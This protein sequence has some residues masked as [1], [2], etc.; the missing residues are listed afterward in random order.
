MGRS[1][2]RFCTAENRTADPSHNKTELLQFN[3]QGLRPHLQGVSTLR[4]SHNGMCVGKSRGG[5]FL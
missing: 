2:Q 1:L 4:Q 3:G 5:F